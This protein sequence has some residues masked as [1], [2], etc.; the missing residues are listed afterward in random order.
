MASRRGVAV[1]RRGMAEVY[2]DMRKSKSGGG[3]A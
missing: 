3:A 1:G 2:F